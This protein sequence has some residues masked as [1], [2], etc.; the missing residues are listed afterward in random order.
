M[1]HN[2]RKIL[3]KTV[4]EKVFFLMRTGISWSDIQFLQGIWGNVHYQSIY[5]RFQKWNRYEILQDAWKK[6]FEKYKTSRLSKDAS[7]FTDLY[8]DTTMIKNLAERDCT[9]ANPTDWGRLATKVSIMIDKMKIPVSEPVFYP[10]NRNDISTIEGTIDK[11]PFNLRIDGRRTLKLAGDKAYRSKALSQ[12]ILLT[13][14]IRIVAQPKKNESVQL[15]SV[16]ET[17]LCLKTEF[18]LN[19]SLGCWKEW[20]DFAFGQ[21]EMFAI[22]RLFGSFIFPAWHSMHWSAIY[23]IT[24]CSIR[25]FDRLTSF[26]FNYMLP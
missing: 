25:I 15:T 1:I 23:R 8:I 14:K 11:M 22:T 26:Y 5:K 6:L 17:K 9:G 7:H 18:T 24:S 10:A 12:K 19:I 2:T 13:K 4:F 16:R 21:I 20:S 3:N